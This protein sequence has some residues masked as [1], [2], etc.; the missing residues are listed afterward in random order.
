MDVASTGEGLAFGDMDGFVHVWTTSED[1]Q[2]SRFTQETEMPDPIEP[3]KQ[4]DWKRD[5]LVLI[6]LVRTCSS[7]EREQTKGPSMS[8][9]C[10]ITPT[11]CCLTLTM[12]ITLATTRPSSILLLNRIP[13][14][15]P[16]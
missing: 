5:T 1:A 4:V 6:P 15:L 12:T 9:E 13:T 10:P 8:S 2:F 3:V 11:H 7:D 16:I 14:F